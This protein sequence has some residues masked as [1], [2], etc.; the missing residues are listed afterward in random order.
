MRFILIREIAISDIKKDN[1]VDF[2]DCLFSESL[3][4]GEFEYLNI[5]KW[6]R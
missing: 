3:I 4:S 5:K 1:H 6:I 2:K